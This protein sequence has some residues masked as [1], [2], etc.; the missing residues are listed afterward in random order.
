MQFS[1][2]AL[3]PTRTPSMRMERMMRTFF[4]TT[5]WRPRIE[6]LIVARSSICVPAPTM[7]SAE[8]CAR[9]WIG[10][11]SPAS[12]GISNGTAP[13]PATTGSG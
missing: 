2:L 7:Q 6:C 4:P 13:L 10:A 3:S 8:S 5:H 11:A 1:S 9:A 12:R